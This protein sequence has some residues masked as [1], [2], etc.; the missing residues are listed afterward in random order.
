MIAAVVQMTS[1]SDLERN[2]ASAAK[3]IA[4]A[5]RRGAELVALPEMFPLMR[6]E[7]ADP[8][9]AQPQDVPGGR[10]PRF[11]AE[12]AAEHGIVLAGGT[13]AERIPG[14]ARVFNTSTVFG[15]TGE[16]LALYRKIHLFDVDLPG[17]T[18]RESARVAAGA[19]VVIAKT[20]LGTLGLSVCYDMR[21]PELYRQLGDRG[22]QVLLVPSAF[23]VPTGRDHWEVLLR[24]RAIE[25]QCFVVASAQFGEHN[26]TRRSF[27]RSLIADPWGTVL[28][29]VPDGEGVGLAE[30]D[31]ARQAEIRTRLPALRHRRL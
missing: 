1:G 3:W 4:E 19:E 16:L 31:F 5:A 9:S 28:C 10:V 15:P 11:L 13:F 25:N 30:L 21:F 18:L 26:A 17:A 29:V 23:T 2:L 20:A 27:G 8:A 12:Q 22:A 7:G 24:A 14:D 6:E